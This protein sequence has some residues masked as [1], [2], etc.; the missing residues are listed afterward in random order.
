MAR[1][2]ENN[3]HVLVSDESF[4]D[5][6]EIERIYLDPAI[7]EIHD[8]ARIDDC[9]TELLDQ[10]GNIIGEHAT[11]FYGD[12]MFRNEYTLYENVPHVKIEK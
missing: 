8:G 3:Q 9:T 2:Y 1:Y 10:Y 5:Y 12:G 7:T 11:A 6:K 4:V